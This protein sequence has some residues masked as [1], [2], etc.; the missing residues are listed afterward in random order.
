MQPFSPISI[1]VITNLPKY[2]LNKIV[3]LIYRKNINSANQPAFRTH[4]QLE[5]E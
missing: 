2:T 4:K 5:Y 3:H 1:N